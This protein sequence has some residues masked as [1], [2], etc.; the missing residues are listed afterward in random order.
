MFSKFHKRLGVLPAAAIVSDFARLVSDFVKIDSFLRRQGGA[1][2]G[3]AE[4]GLAALLGV[5]NCCSFQVTIVVLSLTICRLYPQRVLCQLAVCFFHRPAIKSHC[6]V[7]SRRSASHRTARGAHQW[8][9]ISTDTDRNRSLARSRCLSKR[10]PYNGNEARPASLCV[11]I[12]I[13]N[14]QGV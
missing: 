10:T 3:A 8:L 2:L 12:W 1:P 5:E 6:Y 9:M 14:A 13:N 7:V 4:R 11:C